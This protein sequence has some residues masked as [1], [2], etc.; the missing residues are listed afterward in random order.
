[1]I[2]PVERA[3][4]LFVFTKSQLELIRGFSPILTGLLFDVL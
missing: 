4:V 3:S 1:M 2:E